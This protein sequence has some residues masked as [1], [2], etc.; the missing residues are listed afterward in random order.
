VIGQKKT[1]KL[2][3][4]LVQR[5]P[6]EKYVRHVCDQNSNFRDQSICIPVGFFMLETVNKGNNKITEL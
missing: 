6:Q 3:T 2:D 1:R 5:K 4:N